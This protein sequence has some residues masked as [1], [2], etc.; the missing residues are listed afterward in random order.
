MSYLLTIWLG[1]LII[2]HRP[3]AASIEEK[4]Q[5]QQQR[6]NLLWLYTKAQQLLLAPFLP[7]GGKYVNCSAHYAWQGRLT[8][9]FVV[10]HNMA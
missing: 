10:R 3:E 7:T 6:F 8:C 5:V 9:T 1:Q 2:G 4:E